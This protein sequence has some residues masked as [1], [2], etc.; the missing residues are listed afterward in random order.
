MLDS[1][2]PRPQSPDNLPRPEH[3]GAHAA[4][5]LAD[6]A[7]FYPED[8]G[9]GESRL[10]AEEAKSYCRRCPVATSCLEEAISRGDAFGVWGGTDASER[11]SLV[12]QR[13]REAG[14]GQAQA[15]PTK[16]A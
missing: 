2:F 15:V 3:W 12:R 1:V 16:A 11:R 14:R 8:F 4:C 5:R 10:V 9:A 6:P 13:V 7:L